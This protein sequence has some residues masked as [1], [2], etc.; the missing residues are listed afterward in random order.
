MSSGKILTSGVADDIIESKVAKK[1]YLGEN[2]Q[3]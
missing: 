2:F 3:M 1:M